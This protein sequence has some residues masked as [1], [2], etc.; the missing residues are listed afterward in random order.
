ERA[1]G[2]DHEVEGDRFGG[3]VLARGGDHQ[4]PR[5]QPG[6]DGG[7]G[8]AVDVGG[9]AR[10]QGGVAGQHPV[11]ADAGRRNAAVLGEHA[12]RQ[13]EGS[14]RQRGLT[15]AGHHRKA[16]NGGGV[17]VEGDRH[18]GGVVARGGDRDRAGGGRRDR[19]T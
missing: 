14:G 1:Q 8:F 7:G 12:Q 16:G 18:G 15:V 10:H 19:G 17:E 6:G 5:R 13:R 9:A 3:C 2:A 11:D 4:R